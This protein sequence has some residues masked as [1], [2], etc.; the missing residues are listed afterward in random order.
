M[1]PGERSS[2][3]AVYAVDPTH[4]RYNESISGRHIELPESIDNHKDSVVVEGFRVDM[5]RILCELANVYYDSGK[6]EFRNENLASLFTPGTSCMDQSKMPFLLKNSGN[7]QKKYVAY[8]E[9]DYSKDRALR[10]DWN[11]FDVPAGW[12]KVASYNNNGD[13]PEGASFEIDVTVNSSKGSWMKAE[14]L[15]LKSLTSNTQLQLQEKTVPVDGKTHH[16]YWKFPAGEGNLKNYRWVRLVLN[17]DGGNVTVANPV[18]TRTMENSDKK[19]E[20]LDENMYPNES[21]RFVPWTSETTVTPRT[22]ALGPGTML[23]YH[24]YHGG[25]YLDLKGEKN[26]DSYSKLYVYYSAG[27]CQGTGVYFD[28]YASGM[29]LLSKDAYADGNFLVKEIALS[30][31]IDTKI[32]QNHRKIVSRLVFANT[33]MDEKCFVYGIFAK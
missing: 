16:L 17:S 15:L 2:A 11:T 6:K 32:S 9:Y 19:Y 23:Q 1:K 30:D 28:S 33:K 12:H 8:A 5:W 10:R 4:P 31:I 14:V 22:D 3:N 21:Y 18:L 13:L 24:N 25:A 27:T 29:Q 7:L 26:A 20:V